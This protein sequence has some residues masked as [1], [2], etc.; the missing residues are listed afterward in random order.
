MKKRILFFLLS[1]CMVLMG[2]AQQNVYQLPSDSIPSVKGQTFCYMLPST[3]LKVTVTLTKIHEIQGYYAEY[4]QSLLNLDNIISENRTFY[5]VSNITLEPLQVPDTAHLYLVQLSQKQIKDNQLA[6][7]TVKDALIPSLPQ[8][9]QSYSTQVTLIPD[10]FKNYPNLSYT[11]TKDSF[12]ETKI[13]DGVVTQVPSSRTKLIAKTDHQKAQE[14]A[15]IIGKSRKAQYDLVAGT[16]ETAYSAEALKLMLDELKQWEQNYLSLFTGLTLEEE[17]IYTF[18]VVPEPKQ[19]QMPLFAC[20]RTLGFSLDVSNA[21]IG[22]VYKLQF[23]P[24]Y[25]A[26]RIQQLANNGNN[27]PKANRTGYRIRKAMPVQ[28]SLLLENKEIFDFGIFNMSQF[29]NIQ[30]LPPHHDHIEIQNFGF[31]Y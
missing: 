17:I 27:S 13:I 20:N 30:I 23:T 12:V 14:A 26:G 6:R 29:G 16:Q 28:I 11:E 19:T 1:G 8:Q 9:V 3:A 4:A 15:D 21:D 22:S 31:I 18:Y 5:K 7:M 2:Q 10:F 24:V 25:D